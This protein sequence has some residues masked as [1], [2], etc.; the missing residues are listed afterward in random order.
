MD[1]KNILLLIMALSLT[2]LAQTLFSQEKTGSIS[3][4]VRDAVTKQPLPGAN[5]FVP[6]TT[7]GTT[8]DDKGYYIIK[9]IAPGKYHV[10]ASIIGYESSS[11]PDVVVI[12]QRN[13]MISFNL[14]A[15]PV[16]MD[17]VTIQSDYFAKPDE[18]VVSIRTLSPEEIRRSPGS[19]EDIFRVMQSMPGVATAGGKS[20]QL[21]VRGGSPDENLTLLDNIEIYNPIHFARTGESMGIISIVNPALLEK[22]DFLT[23]GFPAKYGDKMSSVFDMT[24]Q[25]GNK[26][27]YNTDVNANVAGFGVTM[28]GPLVENSSMVF[29][30]RRG[31]FDILTSL[32]NKPAAPRY[33]DAVGKIT[34]DLDPNNRISLVG[35]YYLDQID[36]LGSTKESS[37]MSKYDYLA[38]DDYGSALGLNWRLLI[39]QHA[40]VL[41]TVSFTGNG[42][43]T[44]QGSETNRA[45]RGEDILEEEFAIK[46]ELA[47]QFSPVLDLKIGGFVKLIDSKNE[48]WTPEDTT[49]SGVIIPAATI[50]YIPDMTSKAALYVQSSYRIVQPVTISVGLRFDRFALTN[51]SNVSP[52]LALSYRFL[53]S[54]SLNLAWGKYIQSPASYQISPD[55]RNLLLK[56]STAFHYVAGLEHRLADDTRATVEVYQKELSNLVVDPD[57]SNLLLNTGSGYARGV[58]LSLQKKFTDGFVGSASYSYS[59]SKRRDNST[60]ALYDFEFDRP[61]IMNLIAGMEVGKGWQIGAKFQYAS[62]NPYTPVVGAVMKNGVYYVVD[63]GYNS[64]RYPAYHKLDVRID[65][66]FHF[67]SWTLMAYVDLWNVYNRQ[68][69]LSYSYKVDSD[70]IITT[71]P[72]YDFGVLPIIGLSAQF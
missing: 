17:A 16:E 61:H 45:L 47:Y 38:R 37:A 34:Y 12:P 68:N 13:K 4:E 27:L 52:R 28:D 31:F 11:N 6:G 35:F 59:V 40:F 67:N 60:Q 56:S 44:R 50:S 26:E 5:V 72:R 29:S 23:G 1:L 22:V 53:E 33:Y 25:N 9:N 54:T 71:T 42:W 43:T 51:E 55:P 19:A 32:L 18:N 70:G 39:S 48:S 20:A 21:I 3:G 46:S 36:K 69:I 65:K 66:K 57:S 64:A 24:L 41:T 2:L 58:E 63:G 62:G 10:K 49:R 8:S 7:I 15:S 30:L 14:K